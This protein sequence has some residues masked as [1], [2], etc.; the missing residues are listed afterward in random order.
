MHRNP[1]NQWQ[2]YAEKDNAGGEGDEEEI[3]NVRSLQQVSSSSLG[4]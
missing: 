4:E 3:G 2:E 1:Q